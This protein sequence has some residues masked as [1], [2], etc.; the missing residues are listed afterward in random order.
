MND[1]QAYTTGV[2]E[3][4]D[5]HPYCALDI[6]WGKMLCVLACVQLSL[7]HPTLPDNA[8]RLAREFVDQTISEIRTV[9]PYLADV[10]EKGNHPE[11]D[12]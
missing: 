8:R 1:V 3:L 10:L 4:I 7:R 11:Y 9:V 12:Q 5:R 2:M 6:G